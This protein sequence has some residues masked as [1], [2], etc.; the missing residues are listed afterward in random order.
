[1]NAMA[2]L[3]GHGVLEIKKTVFGIIARSCGVLFLKYLFPC[4]SNKY[5]NF[6][7]TKTSYVR[8]YNEY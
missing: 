3:V 6:A 7:L 1:M 5:L 2:S 4:C 8:E